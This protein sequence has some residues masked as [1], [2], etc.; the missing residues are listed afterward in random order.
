MNG[1]IKKFADGQT[2]VGTDRDVRRK[3]ASWSRG[4]LSG[5]VG[6]SLQHEGTTVIIEGTGDFW[7]SDDLEVNFFEPT[8]SYI[9]RRLQK[10]L[11][12]DD[13][14]LLITSA[15]GGKYYKYEVLSLPP[16]EL[17]GRQMFPVKQGVAG[18]W[19]TLEI[20]ARTKSVIFDYKDD[21]I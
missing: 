12:E 7:Q 17:V 2:E 1:W 15:P 21:R 6:V 10:K 14:W 3:R 19:L 4:R 16:V 8:P 11:T 20:D 5:M 9:T 18:K 13:R